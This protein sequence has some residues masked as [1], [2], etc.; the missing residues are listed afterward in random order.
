[1]LQEFGFTQGSITAQLKKTIDFGRIF[2]PKGPNSQP[3]QPLPAGPLLPT[4]VAPNRALA[5]LFARMID[6]FLLTHIEGRAKCL[7]RQA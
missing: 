1:M 4:L 6:H 5:H 3:Q 2:Q 7:Q